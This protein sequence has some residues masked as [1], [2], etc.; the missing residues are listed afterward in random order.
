M[1][2]ISFLFSAIVESKIHFRNIIYPKNLCFWLYLSPD[3]HHLQA[4]W[5]LHRPEGLPGRHGQPPRS[6]WWR[7]GEQRRPHPAVCWHRRCRWKSPGFVDLWKEPGS[8]RGTVCWL[9]WCNCNCSPVGSIPDAGGPDPR[10]A[11]SGLRRHPGSAAL[12]ERLPERRAHRPGRTSSAAFFPSRTRAAASAAAPAQQ[13]LTDTGI[14]A[15]RRSGFW[16]AGGE[17]ALQGAA[18]GAGHLFPLLRFWSPDHWGC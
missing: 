14:S 13:L 3:H 17:G 8:P 12:S 10:G 16:G 7:N 11:G 15:R 5:G 18:G 4:I 1:L 2:K 6:L 9:H